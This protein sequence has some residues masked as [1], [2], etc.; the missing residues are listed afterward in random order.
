MCDHEKL[1]FEVVEDNTDILQGTRHLTKVSLEHFE[2]IRS[3]KRVFPSTSEMKH[4]SA[5]QASSSS[6]A[7][8]PARRER[9]KETYQPMMTNTRFTI[10]ANAPYFAH[11]EVMASPSIHSKSQPN[12]AVATFDPFGC[13]TYI[14][15]T[16]D[17]LTSLVILQAIMMY[18]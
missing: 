9:N 12:A 14:S 8:P 17:K 1:L 18:S 10:S 15:G 16:E 5:I 2:R 13:I 3:R 6:S 7:S 11:D 4:L